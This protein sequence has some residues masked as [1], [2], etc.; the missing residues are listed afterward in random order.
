MT[1]TMLPE[2]ISRFSVL[3]VA[4]GLSSLGGV[5]ALPISSPTSPWSSDGIHYYEERIMW[6]DY[7]G[8]WGEELPP[9]EGANGDVYWYNQM[10][11]E[12]GQSPLQQGWEVHTLMEFEHNAFVD[13]KQDGIH[14]AGDRSAAFH[15]CANFHHPD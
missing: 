11:D 15:V 5:T 13:Y 7:P 2:K 3:V 4:L 6:K 12:M 10:L 14:W 1:M 8:D 9:P